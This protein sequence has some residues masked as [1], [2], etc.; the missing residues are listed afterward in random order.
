[1]TSLNP[2]MIA[3]MITMLKL[4]MVAWSPGPGGSCRS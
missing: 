2:P 1:M 4:A 3:A